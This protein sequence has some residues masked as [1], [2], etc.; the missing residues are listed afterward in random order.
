MARK[1][2]CAAS[3]SLPP[4]PRLDLLHFLLLGSCKPSVGREAGFSENSDRIIGFEAVALVGIDLVAR[5]P[6]LAAR[7]V[8]IRL[9]S[10]LSDHSQAGE[11]RQRERSGTAEPRS[12]PHLSDPRALL[13]A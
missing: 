13:L 3:A 9:G 7:H 1:A 10:G 11:R 4:L 8:P 2:A 6:K 5:I 12:L